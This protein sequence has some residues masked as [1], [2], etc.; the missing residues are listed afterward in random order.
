VPSVYDLKPRFQSLLRPL[1]RAC[2]DHGVTP[3]QLTLAALLG[4]LVA[5]AA[6]LLAREH[7]RV[8]LVLPGWLL[9]RM[10]LNAMDGMAAREHGLQSPLGAVLNEV[11]D[12]LSDL[13][14]YLPLA[15]LGPRL[16]WP[17]TAFCLG[18]LLTEF[19]GVL[20]QALGARRHFEGPMG[21]SDRALLVGLLALVTAIVPRLLAAWPVLLA[22]G[23]LFALATVGNRLGAALGELR[24]AARP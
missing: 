1:V 17:A 19:A 7:P 2:V 15:F 16:A 21:K 3:N 8:L 23:A 22:L 18:A 10:A 11:G 13:A 6:L 5:G 24:G 4:S 12:V 20:G 14:L 9:A